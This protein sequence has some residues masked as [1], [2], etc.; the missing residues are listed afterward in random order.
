MDTK[1]KSHCKY[2]IN[3][4]LVWCPKYRHKVLTGEIEAFLKSLI[5]SICQSYGYELLNSEVMPDHLHLFISVPPS[6][7]PTDIVKTIK[8]I[9]ALKIFKQFPNL[10][11]QKFWGSGL[12]SKGYYVGTAGTVTSETIQKYINEQ[13]RRN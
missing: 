2:N 11:S 10:K 5:D 9:T 6:I 8:S 7:A 13:K 12:W 1:S 3:Y 4:H